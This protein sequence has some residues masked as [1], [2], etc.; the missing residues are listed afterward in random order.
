MADELAV[1]A[2]AP[3]GEEGGEPKEVAVVTTVPIV[4]LTV[5]AARTGYSPSSW[6]ALSRRR[7][8]G[9]QL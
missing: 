9:R 1:A 5:T 8:R 3:E 4:C 2:P 6:Y 7:R